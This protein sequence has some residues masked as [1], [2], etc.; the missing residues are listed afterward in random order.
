MFTPYSETQ[1]GFE[2]QY[3]VNYLSHF[4][5]TV[6]LTP[7]LRKTGTAERCSRVVNVSSCAHLLGEMRF[8]DVNH[9]DNFLTYEAYA[10]SKLAQVLSTKSL[11]KSFQE[12]HWPIR[13]N[14]VHPGLVGTD[15]FDHSYL[16]YLKF[17]SNILFKV[18]YYRLNRAEKKG[19]L[20]IIP[21]KKF[22][23]LECV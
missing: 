21:K 13:V 1:D 2:E 5:L 10:Q 16:R 4:L 18:S 7:L 19:N 23:L 14:A 11:A 17:I 12:N 8:N 9:R 6:L 3:A 20:L 22:L 15:L